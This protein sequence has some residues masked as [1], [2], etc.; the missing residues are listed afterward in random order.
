MEMLHSYLVS[1]LV[2]WKKFLLYKCS[3]ELCVCVIT[4]W[5]FMLQIAVH[6]GNEVVTQEVQGS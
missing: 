5:V 1:F 3:L 4:E 6:S 2:I